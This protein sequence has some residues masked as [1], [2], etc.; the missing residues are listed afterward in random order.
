MCTYTSID[1][2][3]NTY[4]HTYL[5]D[6]CDGSSGARAHDEC[7]HFASALIPD[8]LRRPVFVRSPGKKIGVLAR[9]RGALQL[10]INAISKIALL[11]YLSE[12]RIQVDSDLSAIYP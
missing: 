8:L 4:I 2:W 9:V 12:I 10:L 7:I 5:R 1:R 11:R 6:S 3:M